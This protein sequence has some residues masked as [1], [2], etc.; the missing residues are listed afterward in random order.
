VGDKEEYPPYWTVAG[1]VQRPNLEGLDGHQE[2]AMAGKQRQHE[3]YGSTS[4]QRQRN[5]EG[6][7]FE[8]RAPHTA[9]ESEAARGSVDKGGQVMHVDTLAGRPGRGDPEEE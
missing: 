6:D 9:E 4:E 1:G 2:A 8:E 5:L 3:G 7:G